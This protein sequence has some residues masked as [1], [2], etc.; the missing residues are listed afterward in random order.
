MPNECLNKKYNI[1]Y[2][3]IINDKWKKIKTETDLISKLNCL[4]TK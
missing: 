2:T 4:S 3:K 1:K